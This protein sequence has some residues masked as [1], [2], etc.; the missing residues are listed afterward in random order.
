M[1]QP[2]KVKAEFGS[3]VLSDEIERLHVGFKVPGKESPR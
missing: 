3:I 1:N 2:G